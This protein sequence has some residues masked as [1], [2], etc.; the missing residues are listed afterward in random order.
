M[1]IL[2]C[3]VS[4][5]SIL[6][7]VFGLLFYGARKNFGE[8]KNKIN[9]YDETIESKTQIIEKLTDQYEKTK[10][11]LTK[12][13]GRNKSVE[14]RTGFIM[15]KIAP[16]VEEFGENPKNVKHLGDPIDFVCFEDDYIKLIEVKT[17]KS[18]LTPKQNKIKKL[19]EEGKVYFKT[20][21]FDYE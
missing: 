6:S 21:R 4:I 5:L 13:R 16:F 7:I 17:G 8:L 2:Y 9:K 14:V 3:I 20:V 15:E 11:N 19:V 1:T 18:R 10:S 12:E